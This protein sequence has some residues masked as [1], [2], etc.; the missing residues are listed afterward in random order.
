MKQMNV[1][2]NILAC[3][4]IAYFFRAFRSEQPS[5]NGFLNVNAF[6]PLEQVLSLFDDFL[7]PR[8][9]R[10]VISVPES[11]MTTVI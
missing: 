3:A 8:L 11:F 10:N 4:F 9:E 6:N 5:D 1:V 7:Q 2:I